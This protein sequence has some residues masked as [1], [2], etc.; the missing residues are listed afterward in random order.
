MCKVGL[1]GAGEVA[2]SET[3]TRKVRDSMIS[4]AL[5]WSIW[6]VEFLA[7][8]VLQLSDQ[9]MVKR[10]THQIGKMSS[11]CKR[12]RIGSICKTIQLR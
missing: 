2:G 10:R 4:L 5:V 1:A 8:L 12:H 11:N 7:L 3:L 6:S 9:D